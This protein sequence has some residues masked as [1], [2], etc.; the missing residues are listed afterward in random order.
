MENNEDKFRI[1]ITQIKDLNYLG[2][3]YC[4]HQSVKL[5]S[6]FRNLFLIT[7]KSIPIDIYQNLIE[8]GWTRCGNRFYKKNYETSCCRLYQPR[9]NIN[10]FKITKQQ[11]KVMKKFRKYLSGEYETNNF[12][13]NI[14]NSN[15][16][17]EKE[18]LKEED[19]IQ[20]K[21]DE[22]LRDYITSTNFLDILN[23]YIQNEDEINLV[24]EK[25]IYTK[26]RKNN[27]KKF[28]YDYSC[29]L[30]YIIKNILVSIRKKNEKNNNINEIKNM[31]DENADYKNFINDI[32]N[33]INKFYKTDDIYENI[34][35]NEKTGHINFKIKN[36]NIIQKEIKNEEI[37][38]NKKDNIKENKKENIKENKI[39]LNEINNPKGKEKYTFE[40]FKEIVTEPE[41]YLPLKHIYTIE[42]TDKIG[43]NQT[44]ERFLLYQKYQLKIHKEIATVEG[45]NN[46][47]GISPV[48][49]KQ[50]NLP[51][52]L[53]TK[54]KHPELYP[55]YYGTH[56]LIHRIDGKIIAVTVIDIFPKYFESLY[57]YYDT[58]FSFLNLGVFTAI[59]EIEYMKSFQELIDKNLTYYTMGEMSISVK[60]LKY[61]GDYCPTEIMDPYTGIYVPLT[62][63]LKNQ[64][65]DNECHFFT[66]LGK[67]RN[68]VGEHI[69]KEEIDYFY[70]NTQI[71]V[72]GD[73]ILIE[74]FLKLY[75]EG[76]FK[77]QDSIRNNLRRLLEIID[78]N[79]FSKIE[80]F[81]DET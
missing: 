70:Y 59:R 61:K 14:K 3:G 43:L 21:I 47:I 67:N 32:Y 5:K 49:K 81:Y 2:C 48:I 19:E 60:K 22:K 35:F 34:S 64:I 16:I 45:Y 57:C 54:T 73:K 11:E 62:N 46:F 68:L 4:Q 53:N 17:K 58:D 50:V 44:E 65:A 36:I 72:F 29:D 23:K 75:F 52:D 30:I 15:D 33:D 25:L 10:N 18:K 28:E 31:S 56:N 51:H 69:S 63:E 74:D 24:Y 76:N 13:N 20:K 37:N 7:T 71:R 27:N 80:F 8:K 77:M 39:N 9:V 42:L 41:I 40:Y 26:I 1:N 6:R 78:L 38:E 55:K 79:T 12:L 66:L